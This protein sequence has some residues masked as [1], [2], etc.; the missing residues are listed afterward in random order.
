MGGSDSGSSVAV[1]KPAMARPETAWRCV[2]WL[3]TGS[4]VFFMVD[5]MTLREWIE[6]LQ[7]QEK[8]AALFVSPPSYRAT[9]G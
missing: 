3:M 7:R 1:S 6:V 4:A 5:G 9:F 2:E 8:L